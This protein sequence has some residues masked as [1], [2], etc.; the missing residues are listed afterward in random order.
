MAHISN[1]PPE[2]VCIILAV[3]TL[4]QLYFKRAVC[5]RWMALIDHRF[6][7]QNS[8]GI[9]HCTKPRTHLWFRRRLV[10]FWDS[11][12]KALSTPFESDFLQCSF[13][14]GYHTK[15]MIDLDALR[16]LFPNITRLVASGSVL[17]AYQDLSPFLAEWGHQL[18]SVTLVDF[19]KCESK[20]IFF[21][22]MR[23]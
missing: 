10:Q 14:V 15:G 13:N 17:R 2:M 9:F 8:I 5:P 7:H 11:F 21:Y 6:A 1:L 12:E 3:F 4:Q 16:P 23:L 22:F 19:P 20:Y 18:T